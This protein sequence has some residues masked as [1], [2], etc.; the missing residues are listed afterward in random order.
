MEAVDLSAFCCCRCWSGSLLFWPRGLEFS[1]I[2]TAVGSLWIIHKST[3]IRNFSG[4]KLALITVNREERHAIYFSCATSCPLKEKRLQ[5]VFTGVAAQ[6]RC[7]VVGTVVKVQR[8]PVMLSSK[9]HNL[10]L[11]RQTLKVTYWVHSTCKW[12]KSNIL[13]I[14]SEFLHLMPKGIVYIARCIQVGKHRC[15]C[16][17]PGQQFSF[18]SGIISHVKML[19]GYLWVVPLLQTIHPFNLLII[20]YLLWHPVCSAFK[21]MIHRSARNQRLTGVTCIPA[22]S[23][24]ETFQTQF[25]LLS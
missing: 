16:I 2:H 8:V 7:V 9:T 12:R 23:G 19:S 5:T 25:W 14:F 13:S 6:S 21:P 15:L 18:H 24:T 11:R 22:P 1:N 3:I 20:S 10:N 4:Y 17:C